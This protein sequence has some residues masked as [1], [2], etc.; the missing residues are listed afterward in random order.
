MFAGPVRISGQTAFGTLPLEAL[1]L[2]TFWGKVSG[3]PVCAFYG[4]GAMLAQ[5]G[6]CV[7][8]RRL[9]GPARWEIVPHKLPCYG[10][11]L[12]GASGAVFDVLGLMGFGVDGLW[13]T[14]GRK[15]WP[16]Q[17]P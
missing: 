15:Q 3:L 5:R 12:W 10:A 1:G 14:M 6:I 13:R 16:A 17:T 7:Q 9:G 8:V 4:D 11:S 2:A